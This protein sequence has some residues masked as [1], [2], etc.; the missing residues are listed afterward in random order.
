MSNIKNHCIK[1][2]SDSNELH[3]DVKMYALQLVF[4]VTKAEMKIRAN[5]TVVGFCTNSEVHCLRKTSFF[6][7]FIS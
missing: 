7:S 1:R 6:K 5:I 4:N 2:L 3:S